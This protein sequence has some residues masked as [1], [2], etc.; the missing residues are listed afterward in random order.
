M[1]N[2]KTNTNKNEYGFIEAHVGD[3]HRLPNRKIVWVNHLISG[4]WDSESLKNYMKV[5]HNQFPYR[6]IEQWENF[7]RAVKSTAKPKMI[8]STWKLVDDEWT[9]ELN[10]YYAEKDTRVIGA[11]PQKAKKT[12]KTATHEKAEHDAKKYARRKAGKSIDEESI[13]ASIKID[14]AT[15]LAELKK[16]YAKMGKLIKAYE[17]N[18]ADIEKLKGI[19]ARQD[20]AQQKRYAR[21]AE[22]LAK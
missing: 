6:T 9:V 21:L 4:D 11:R 1:K 12:P 18:A 2:T 22:L 16:E 13:V 10:K 15:D 3:K 7:G 19:I 14:R 5:N 17:K 8:F 20:E